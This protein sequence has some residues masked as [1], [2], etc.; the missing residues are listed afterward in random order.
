MK[1]RWMRSFNGCSILLS[2]K[3]ST[4]LTQ[5][6]LMELENLMAAVNCFLGS[7]FKSI[8]EVLQ[9]VPLI[10]LP[11]YM[12]VEEKTPEGKKPF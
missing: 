2:A 3:A 1:K 4:S 7:S 6:I 11:N 12:D 9:L 10:L 8:E 5:Q